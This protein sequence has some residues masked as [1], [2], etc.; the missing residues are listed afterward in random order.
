MHGRLHV[1]YRI[2]LD[3]LECNCDFGHPRIAEAAI[4]F[5]KC[6]FNLLQEYTD[7]AQVVKA[8]PDLP[9]AIRAAIIAMVKAG[10]TK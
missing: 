4:D 8:W 3:I 5:A 6:L 10:G 1:L 2:C 9:E 7:L